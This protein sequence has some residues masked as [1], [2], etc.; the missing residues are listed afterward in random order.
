MHEGV[1]MQLQLSSL[2]MVLIIMPWKWFLKKFDPEGTLSV[3]EL[4]HILEEHMLDYK[5][6]VIDDWLDPRLNVK[7]ALR[8]YRKWSLIASAPK[9]G[10]IPIACTCKV[11]FPNCVCQCT[12]L[13]ASLFNPD[14]RVTPEYIA[15]TVSLCKQCRPCRARPAVR[16]CDSSRRPSA[17]RRQSIPRWLT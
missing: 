17:T 14:T 12:I 3:P 16:R 4:R 6:L 2:K 13:L 15:V 11:C 8:I 10:A 1:D 9:R 5:G 7:Q